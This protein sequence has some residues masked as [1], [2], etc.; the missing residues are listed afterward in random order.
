MTGEKIVVFRLNAM[1]DIV[2]TIP[3]LRALKNTGAQVHVVVNE[4]WCALAPFIPA[5]VHYYEGGVKLLSLVSELRALKPNKVYDLQGKLS[6]IIMRNLLGAPVMGVYKKRTLAEQ[7]VAATKQ[8]P[9][10]LKDQRP[11]WKKYAQVCGVEAD[12]SPL[13]EMPAEYIDECRELIK[14]HDLIEKEFLLIHPDASKPGK[15]IPDELLTNLAPMLDLPVAIVGTGTREL[16]VPEKYIDLRNEFDL[17]HL[18]G[19]LSLARAV[20]S[21]DSGPMHLARAVDV[22][23]VAL[24]FQ[25]DVSLGFAPIPSSKTVVVSNELECKPC[26]LHGQNKKCPLGHFKCRNISAEQVDKAL[27]SVINL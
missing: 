27:K 12:C 2:L 24:F 18:P 25:T 13:F 8:F 9:I 3:T 10:K 7:I 5:A 20:V 16:D 23:L 21:S 15:E 19:V 26:S 1:G 6:T 11:V 4:K 22:P 17:Y 14:K